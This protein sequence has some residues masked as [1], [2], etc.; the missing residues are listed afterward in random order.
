MKIFFSTSYSFRTNNKADYNAIVDTLEEIFGKEDVFHASDEIDV[1][2][3][4]SPDAKSVVKAVKTRQDALKNSDVLIADVTDSS[5]GVGYN[6][7]AAVSLKKPTLVIRRKGEA[8]KQVHHPISSGGAKLLSYKEYEDTKEIK[9]ILRKFER[10]AT[11]MLDTKFILIISPQI[12]RYLEW[13]ADFRRMHKAQIVR[14]AVEEMM[15]KDAEYKK[16]EKEE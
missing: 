7:H 8:R 16:A 10:E 4:S 6:I 3:D 14:N 9:E 15:E 1:E 11:Q 12:D 2:L 5:A 13:A